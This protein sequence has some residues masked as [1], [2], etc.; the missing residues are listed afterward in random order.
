MLHSFTRTTDITP[1]L[2]NLTQPF[3]I[4]VNK[5]ASPV[6]ASD[7][8]E[9]FHQSPLSSQGSAMTQSTTSLS[10]YT[11]QTIPQY[12]PYTNS[13]LQRRCSIPSYIPKITGRSQYNILLPSL[14][15]TSALESTLIHKLNRKSLDYMSRNVPIGKIQIL[16]SSDEG[17]FQESRNYTGMVNYDMTGYGGGYQEPCMVEEMQVNQQPVNGIVLLNSQCG[18]TRTSIPSLIHREDFTNSVNL[19]VDPRNSYIECSRASSVSSILSDKSNVLQLNLRSDATNSLTAEEE[20]TKQNISLESDK[21][22]NSLKNSSSETV[23]LIEAQLTLNSSIKKD[24]LDNNFRSLINRDDNLTENDVNKF[25]VE[26]INKVATISEETLAVMI[27]SSTK[28][29]NLSLVLPSTVHAVVTPTT[30]LADSKRIAKTKKRRYLKKNGKSIKHS[31]MAICNDDDDIE[32]RRRYICKVCSKG[33][34]TSGH[35]A[36]HNRIHT[37]EKRH[38]CPFEGCNQR[39]NRHDNCLQHYRTHLRRLRDYSV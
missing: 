17:S 32:S 30:I 23:S 35:L 24:D 39:F 18:C 9:T 21:S 10:M 22:T 7:N 34:T 20:Y 26:V 12:C 13:Y 36:R 5:T 14:K 15:T 28:E 19:D 37:G 3:P 16:R 38:V 4:Y 25:D 1:P 29:S 33:F 11:Y 31:I 8:I 2:T 27:S 6:T